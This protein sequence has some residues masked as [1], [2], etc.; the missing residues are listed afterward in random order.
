MKYLGQNPYRY[1][2]MQ[3]NEG[4]LQMAYRYGDRFQLWLFPR[5]IE[6]YVGPRDPV[7]AYDAF[8]EAL[9]FNALGIE[10][11]GNQSGQ[12]RIRSQGDVK[13]VCLWLLLR[14][15]DFPKTGA[16]N[17][18]QSFVHLAHGRLKTGPQ[19]HC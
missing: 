3:R 5:S 6:D 4:G 9:D 7:R 17:P 1:D 13:A 11:D 16:R 12:L 18:S 2:K 8:V 15:Q 19:D 10:I 14:D